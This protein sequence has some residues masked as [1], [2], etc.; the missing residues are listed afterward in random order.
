MAK[1]LP[2]EKKRKFL[3]DALNAALTAKNLTEAYYIDRAEQYLE[4]YDFK[5]GLNSRIR[6][7]IE[8]EKGTDTIIRLTVEVRN[9]D[10][11]MMAI[12]QF[13]GL[14][15]PEEMPPLGGEDDGL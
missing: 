5:A 14:K 8:D 7:S 15:P 2:H 4:F 10:K 9:T 1:P 12:L 3:K 6:R 11:H 13:L